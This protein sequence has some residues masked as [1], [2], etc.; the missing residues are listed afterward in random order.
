MDLAIRIEERAE[1]TEALQVV[2]MEVAE[3]NVDP[4]GA[5]ATHSDAERTHA[6]T[7]VEHQR[8]APVSTHLHAGG[9]AAVSKCVGPGRGQRAAAAPHADSHSFARQNTA[10]TPCISPTWPKSGYAVT[11][12]GG[13]APLRVVARSLRWAGTRS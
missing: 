11:S 7:C 6:R 4:G 9:V 13:R 10:R 1:E 8:F 3:Q 5:V 2:E 12:N